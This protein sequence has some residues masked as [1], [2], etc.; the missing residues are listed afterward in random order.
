MNTDPFFTAS[1]II[2]AVIGI[3]VILFAFNRILKI[4]RKWEEACDLIAFN[5][6]QI[7]V[8]S[9]P[10]TA[11]SYDK[12]DQEFAKLK[13]SQEGEE[14]ITLLWDTFTN[15]FHK[16]TKQRQD[17]SHLSA[18]SFYKV[19][20][21]NRLKALARELEEITKERLRSRG[22]MKELQLL[23]V[24]ENSALLLHDEIASILNIKPNSNSTTEQQEPAIDQEPVLKSKH[25][26]KTEMT[27]QMENC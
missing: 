19:R 1:S 3:P 25:Q 2:A 5:S 21:E 12:I 9:L 11:E 14:K 18:S 10:V 15:R 23:S 22:N 26:V 7:L 27:L 6:L 20:L 4:I 17:G 13:A 24:R 8:N 16:I